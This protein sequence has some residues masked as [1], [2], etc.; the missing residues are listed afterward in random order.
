MSDDEKADGQNIAQTSPIRGAVVGEHATVFQH[1][2]YPNSGKVLSELAETVTKDVQQTGAKLLAH[3]E[4]FYINAESQSRQSFYLACIV[5]LIGLA[6]IVAA[7]FIGLFTD[8]LV[9]SAISGVSGISFEVLA[10]FILQ[11]YKQA[12][13]QLATFHQSIDDMHRFLVANSICESLEGKVKEDTRSTLV[14][15]IARFSRSQTESGA[16]DTTIK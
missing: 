7:V 12:S 16:K 14:L 11:L 2:I 6:L 10:G 5:G 15:D 4:T 1:F 8:K 9:I 3:K 13:V